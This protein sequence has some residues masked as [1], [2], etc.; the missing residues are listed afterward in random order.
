MNNQDKQIYSD[1]KLLA[2]IHD[3]KP[4]EEIRIKK[5]GRGE[6]LLIVY[7]ESK[8]FFQLKDPHQKELV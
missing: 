6:P 4:F 3:L 2:I 7:T 8:I 1:D 5:D